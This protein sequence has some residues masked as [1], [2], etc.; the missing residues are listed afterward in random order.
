MNFKSVGGRGNG[1][2]NRMDQKEKLRVEDTAA[3]KRVNCETFEERLTGP[4]ITEIGD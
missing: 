1:P 4:V 2:G 3:Y